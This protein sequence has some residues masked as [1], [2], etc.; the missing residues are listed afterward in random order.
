MRTLV[1]LFLSVL[2]AL[3]LTAQN[4][5]AP[6]QDD[7]I[8]DQVRLRLTRDRDVGSSNIDVKVKDGVVELI[9][10]VRRDNVK[11]KAEKLAK[12]VKG[13]NQVVNNL[14]VGPPV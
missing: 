3:V 1:A 13:V 11:S 12:K 7:I 9:G 4:T 2:F 14:K 6:S 8:Y 5:A 10:T